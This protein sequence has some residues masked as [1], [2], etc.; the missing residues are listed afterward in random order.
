MLDHAAERWGV[1]LSSYASEPLIELLGNTATYLIFVFAWYF[2]QGI[3][4]SNLIFTEYQGGSLM[5][6]YGIEVLTA[7]MR[8]VDPEMVSL[9]FSYLLDLDVYGFLPSAFGSLYIDFGLGGGLAITALWG[10]FTAIVYRNTRR[11]LDARWFIFA[12]FVTLGILTSLFNTPVGFSNG[13]ITHFWLVS[14]F[15]L[16]GKN[17]QLTRP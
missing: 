5:G 17:I 9:S 14:T 11:G 6:I 8:R 2:V 12:P 10:W 1:T 15:L 3:S 7:V 4:I 16:M 13:L